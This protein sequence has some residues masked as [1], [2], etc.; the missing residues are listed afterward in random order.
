MCSVNDLNTRD[1][2]PKG[3]LISSESKGRAHLRA[4]FLS[5]HIKDFLGFSSWLQLALW[6]M[7]PPV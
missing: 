3:W 2:Q 4:F 5:A 1:E 6:I 7:S